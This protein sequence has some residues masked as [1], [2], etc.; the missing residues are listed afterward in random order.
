MS[1][2]SD[3]YTMLRS[4]AHHQKS[5][6]ISYAEFCDYMKRFAQHHIDKKPQLLPFLTNPSNAMAKEIDQLEKEGLLLIL[7]PEIDKKSLIIISY[8]T[9][10]YATLYKE[11]DK[12]PTIPFPIETDLPKNIPSEVVDKRDASSFLIERLNEKETQDTKIKIN[13]YALYGLI[14]PHNLPVLLFPGSLDV[15]YLL[16]ISISKL[17]T[18]LQKEEFHDYFLKKIRIS[19]PGRE[20]SVKTF[21]TQIL[22]RPQETITA[23]KEGS[24]TFYYWSQLCF[25]IRQDFEKVK[26]YTADDLSLLQ[27]VFVIETCLNYFKSK[28]KKETEKENAFKELTTI[29][30]KPPYYF[31]S[32]KIPLFKDSN[33]NSLLGQYTKEE[34]NS[35]LLNKTTSPEN[36]KLP[37]LLTFTIASGQRFYI[38]KSKVIPLIVRLL[39]DTRETIK[40]NLIKQWSTDCRNFISNETM[41]NQAEFEKKLEKDVECLSPVLYSLLH[42]NFLSLVHFESQSSNQQ[43]TKIINLFSNGKLL[44]YSQL[45]MLSRQE[46]VTDT[47]IMLPFW[48]TIP[49]ISW[50]AKLLFMGSSSKRKNKD[51]KIQKKNELNFSK[52]SRNKF[53]GK[54]DLRG[55]ALNLEKDLVDPGSTLERELISY[56]H[57]WNRLLNKKANENLTE[58]VNAYIRDYLRRTLRTLQG[59]TF[60]KTRINAI[61]K[62]LITS[63]GLQNIPE[64]EALEMYI[65]L[66]IIKIIKN[67]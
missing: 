41:K 47:K 13:I 23:I 4:F 59:S 66:Y 60:S 19:N 39:N 50:I 27:S 17:R 55:G 42:S 22:M 5:A 43:N 14:L 48:Y 38:F 26:D 10:K 8:Y 46:M 61:A 64:K 67:I 3:I 6:N 11:M 53:S 7:N 51:N 21:F 30:N 49:V 56:E 20:L 65:K 18:M 44:P 16:E 54:N 57:E 1:M 9:E 29:L 15:M 34:L 28:V 58:D 40:T 36:N 31:D 12:Q 2:K 25:F 24:E 62:T 32:A 63:P 45:L 52:S 37:D 35:F 33:G